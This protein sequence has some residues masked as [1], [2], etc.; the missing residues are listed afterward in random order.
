MIDAPYD[1]A[2][3]ETPYPTRGRVIGRR[4]RR[5][6]SLIIAKNDLK[7]HARTLSGD[8]TGLPPQARKAQRAPPTH[9]ASQID[10]EEGG[11]GG[12]L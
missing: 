2:V 12:V 6:S 11:G 3:K 7:R 5:R 9:G 10:A 4:R 8:A 1:D